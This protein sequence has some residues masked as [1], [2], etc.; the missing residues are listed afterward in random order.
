MVLAGFRGIRV[1]KKL[2]LGLGVV[3]V[4]LLALEIVLR[5]AGVGPAYRMPH[6]GTW[7][8]QPNL[9]NHRQ[10]T[11]ESSQGFLLNT[12]GDGLRTSLSKA[13][14]KGVLRVALMGDSTV[15]GWG[16]DEGYTLADAV[17]HKIDDLWAKASSRATRVEILNAAQPGYSTTQVAW[18]FNQVV[19][20]YRPDWVLVFL[21]MH[22]YNLALIS[23]RES[24]DGGNGLA[25]QTRVALIQHSRIYTLLLRTLAPQYKEHLQVTHA[26]DEGMRVRRV[27]DD[28]RGQNFD[29]LRAAL[30]KW[31]GGLMVGF[32]P[33]RNDLSYPKGQSAPSRDGEEWV[34]DY[35]RKNKVPLVDVRT[36]CGPD[37][38]S[39]LLPND[40]GHLNA[41]GHAATGAA[42]GEVIFKHIQAQE[43]GR[44]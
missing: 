41:K 30:A 26:T 18:L 16:V 38:K 22:D 11:H 23:D 20:D 39:L 10:T 28:E 5:V 32:L 36:C 4:L 1:M 37:V 34:M 17:Q 35:A 13:K 19:A 29:G 3:L 12:N 31:G 40:P 43:R 21:P 7:L 27:S 14:P 9:K 42:A 6:H 25:A 15:Y 2:G 33:F 8:G 44:K 24:I